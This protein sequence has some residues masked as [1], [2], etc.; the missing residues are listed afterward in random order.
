MARAD[1]PDY[2]SI[3]GVERS[4]DAAALKAA[5]RSACRTAHPDAGGNAA[6][7]QLVTVAYDT[8]RD[9][10]GRASYD[11]SLEGAESSSGFTEE[12]VA[13]LL[14]EQEEELRRQ[15]LRSEGSR[16]PGQ[17]APGPPP[18]P[19]QHPGAAQRP[20]PAEPSRSDRLWVLKV[21]S[22]LYL[23]TTLLALGYYLARALGLTSPLVGE[24]VVAVVVD[25]F[26]GGGFNLFLALAF[27]FLGLAT[28]HFFSPALRVYAM[29]RTRA[30]T[31]T[32]VVLVPVVLLAELLATA[33]GL[34]VL[35]SSVVSAMVLLQVPWR[36]LLHRPRS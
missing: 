22:F 18:R 1:V 3:L 28:E 34:L 19:A 13:R 8:L 35:V 21:R 30:R 29:G 5:Y 25:R 12:D 27:A 7:F 32:L 9:P 17:A 2:Y 36:R 33:G 15:F 23:G 11:R 31:W 14:R 16:S 20:G 6:L 10:V 26:L 24:Q 4:A